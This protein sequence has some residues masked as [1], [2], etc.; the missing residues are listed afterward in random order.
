MSITRRLLQ[1]GLLAGLL[2]TQGQVWSDNQLPDIGTAGVSALSIDQERLYGEAF[3]RVITSYSIH[4]TKLYECI[5][6][7]RFLVW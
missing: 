6:I 5:K 1:A 7:V 2:M 3:M 4:Y